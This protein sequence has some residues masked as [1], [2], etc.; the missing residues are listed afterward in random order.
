M[1]F[2]ISNIKKLTQW[3]RSLFKL[4]GELTLS[5]FCMRNKRVIPLIV[6]MTFLATYYKKKQ[7]QTMFLCAI[8]HNTI[9][10]PWPILNVL[11]EIYVSTARIIWQKIRFIRWS[12]QSLYLYKNALQD[13]LVIKLFSP[14]DNYFTFPS[15][16]RYNLRS[17]N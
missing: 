17:S 2:F 13:E 16:I 10:H 6:E 3:H 12:T 5:R 15:G 14:T 4:G 1:D 7:P 8:I 11:V 9:L